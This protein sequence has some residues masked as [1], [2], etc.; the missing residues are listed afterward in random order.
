VWASR[1]Q[2]TPLPERVAGSEL[3]WSLAAAAATADRSIFLLGG[4]PGA[5]DS[6]ARALRGRHPGLRIAGLRCPEPG[7]ETRADE[8]AELA[9][10]LRASRSDIVFVALGSPKQERFIEQLRHVS[11]AGGLIPPAPA[12]MRRSGLE[13]LHRL[14]CE[15]R[16][17]AR[18]YLVH[19]A[20]FAPSLFARALVV[21]AACLLSASRP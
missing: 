15:P 19:G 2:G 20:L 3:L 10:A 16:R 13:W 11:Y 7:F 8:M 14:A 4:A 21:R 12:W 9:D 17:L 5:A 6:T 1:F 18:R